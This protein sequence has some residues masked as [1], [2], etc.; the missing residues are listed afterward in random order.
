MNIETWEFVNRLLVVSPNTVGQDTA[1]YA[2]AVGTAAANDFTTFCEVYNDLV[3]IE[4]IL[5]NPLGCPIPH[6][7]SAQW[8]IV[9]RIAEHAKPDNIEKLLQYSARMDMQFRVLVFRMLM[10]MGPEWRTNDHVINASIDVADYLW[11]DN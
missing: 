3:K 11:G 7:V 6:K 9:T 1:L 2:G 10:A 4:D 5:A 8:A